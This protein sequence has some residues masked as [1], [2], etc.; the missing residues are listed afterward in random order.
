MKN[1]QILSPL[2]VAV[3]LSW[4]LSAWAAGAANAPVI[5]SNEGA[6]GSIELSNISGTDNQE[7]VA[8][9]PKA[10]A[11]APDAAPVEPTT[12]EAPK[13]PRELHRDKVMQMPEEM[14]AGTSAASRRYKRV[15]LATF[16]ASMQNAAAQA[17]V[18]QNGSSPAQ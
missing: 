16:R 8:A 17:P 10:E 1:F 9:D 7:P 13:D 4:G 2:L 14:P 12:A 6:G 15:D 18:P 11:I 3:G 5:V